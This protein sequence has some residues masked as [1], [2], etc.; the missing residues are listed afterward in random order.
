[1]RLG[2]VWYNV[3]LP[4]L[5]FIKLSHAPPKNMI[6]RDITELRVLNLSPEPSLIEQ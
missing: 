6:S 3:G 2:E 5:P 1:M 4:F